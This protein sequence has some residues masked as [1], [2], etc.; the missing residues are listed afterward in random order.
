MAQTTKIQSDTAPATSLYQC[1]LAAYTQMLSETMMFATKMTNIALTTT[2]QIYVQS[3]RAV[4]TTPQAAREDEERNILA[5]LIAEISGHATNVQ[6]HMLRNA[7][8]WQ[9]QFARNFQ[10]YAKQAERNVVQ[11]TR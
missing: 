9:Q 2:Q 10:Q 5:N 6:N 7:T 3:M 4:P 11:R 8:E 1:Y